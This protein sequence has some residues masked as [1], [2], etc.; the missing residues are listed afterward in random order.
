LAIGGIVFIFV[1][2]LL[3]LFDDRGCHIPDLSDLSL[4]SEVLKGFL[5]FEGLLDLGTEL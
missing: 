3:I 4:V 1:I 2:L 5:L